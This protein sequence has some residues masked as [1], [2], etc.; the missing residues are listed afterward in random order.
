M[1]PGS[2]GVDLPPREEYTKEIT[3]DLNDGDMVLRVLVAHGPVG[4]GFR[5]LHLTVSGAVP[6]DNVS[7]V[8][9]QFVRMLKLAGLDQY[10]EDL[11]SAYAES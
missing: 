10:V 4:W 3:Y 1:S 2:E 8:V 6:P 7:E 5:E 9:K 11:E